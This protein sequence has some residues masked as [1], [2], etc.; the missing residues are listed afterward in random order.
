MILFRMV[1]DR[2][3]SLEKSRKRIE[4]LLHHLAPASFPSQ[5]PAA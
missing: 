4:F 2:D 3:S 5:A 1:R